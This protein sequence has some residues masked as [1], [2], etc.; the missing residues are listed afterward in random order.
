[1]CVCVW[2][3]GGDVCSPCFV[4]LCVCVF[5][6]I[7]KGE[8]STFS[9]CVCVCV[10]AW[11]RGGGMCVALALFICMCVCVCMCTHV[12]LH[13]LYTCVY[14]RTCTH[15]RACLPA[16]LCALVCTRIHAH[17]CVMQVLP[18]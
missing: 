16:F 5:V 4:H 1:M 3:G 7:H 6:K 18:V 15:V 17:L 10:Y 14:M 2:R 8:I 9:L 11:G 13:S 12:V